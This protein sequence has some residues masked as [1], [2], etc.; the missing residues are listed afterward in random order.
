[1]HRTLRAAG[2]FAVLGAL[3]LT[4]SDTALAQEVRA[5]GEGPPGVDIAAFQACVPRMMALSEET[6]AQARQIADIMDRLAATEADPEKNRAERAALRDLL[7][8]Y[9]ERKTEVV[10]LMDAALRTPPPE[11]EDLEILRRLRDT[12]LVGISWNQT[13]FIDCLRDIARAVGVR[14]VM[15][16]DVL[17]NNTVEVTIPRAA[18]D[19]VL[20]NMCTGFDCDWYVH[21]GEIVVIKTIKRNDK[22]LQKFL[23]EHPGWKYWKVK[24]K[25][26][27]E[28]NL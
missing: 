9:R 8:K 15:H 10:T 16:P 7:L 12:E 4:A 24:E 18:A 19:G 28:D 3:A 17:K 2:A 5:H 27:V 25:V 1:M 22:R 21:N 23:D 11:E 26:E 20:R 14:F 13:K 6:L